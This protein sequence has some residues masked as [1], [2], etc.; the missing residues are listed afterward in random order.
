M[1]QQKAETVRGVRI[2]L[3]RHET[4]RHR[5][6]DERI[7]VRFPA[8]GRRL[9]AAWARL[10]RYSRLRRVIL[11]RLIR[12]GFAAANRR[13]FDLLLIG[14]APG[15]EL[16]GMFPLD[17]EANYQGHDGYREAWRVLLEAFEDIRLDPQEVLDLGDRRLV[18]IEWSGHGTGSGVSVS[19]QGFQLYTVR[20]GLVVRQDDF[21]DRAKA[22]EAAGLSGRDA[23]AHS[24]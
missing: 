12:Q 13:D 22:L 8:L 14:F 20:R 16:H 2:P 7:V 15:I 24:S 5:T 3:T 21:A 23:L 4:R 9:L 19:Q 6:L 10:P 11:V 18:T 1:S 17:F